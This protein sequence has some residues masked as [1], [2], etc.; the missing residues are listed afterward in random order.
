[1]P[2]R[3][4]LPS[5]ELLTDAHVKRALRD[6]DIQRM[7]RT[8][9]RWWVRDLAGEPEHNAGSVL[10]V[11]LHRRSEVTE[12]PFDDYFY[13][14]PGLQFWLEVRVKGAVATRE[15]RLHARLVAL[16]LA[17]RLRLPAIETRNGVFCRTPEA[18]AAWCAREAH[19]D[20]VLL[21]KEQHITSAP[22][23]RLGVT[24][25]A[26]SATATAQHAA[27]LP[28][29][30]RLARLWHRFTHSL[31]HVIA[32]PAHAD[33][34]VVEALV[35]EVANTFHGH[36]VIHDAPHH[37]LII[38]GKDTR[39]TRDALNYFRRRAHPERLRRPHTFLRG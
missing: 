20:T 16:T 1:M 37:R 30:G 9:S 38:F 12:E 6:L 36:N 19:P 3:V 17:E 18:F 23:P 2:Y 39:A 7:G 11:Q 8:R 34:T 24:R 5:Y 28:P 29:E 25:Q 4:L 13:I 14:P 22:P 33:A 31:P 10:I 27:P 35:A 15:A 32:L 26:R 21:A